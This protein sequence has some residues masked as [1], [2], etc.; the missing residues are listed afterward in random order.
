MSETM[1]LMERAG[2]LPIEEKVRLAEFL[3]AYVPEE[4]DEEAFIA[5]LDRRRALLESGQTASYPAEEVMAELRA[6]YK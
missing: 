6:R 3:L 2:R 1:Y 5:E 4:A